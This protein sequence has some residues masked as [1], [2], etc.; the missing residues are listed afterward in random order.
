MI[1]C[2]NSAYNSYQ[3]LYNLPPAINKDVQ[4]IEY[5]PKPIHKISRSRKSRIN[6]MTHSEMNYPPVGQLQCGQNQNVATP[7][8]T[9]MTTAPEIN[10]FN[11]GSH[12]ESKFDQNT[13]KKEQEANLT[14]DQSSKMTLSSPPKNKWRVIAILIWV[15]TWGVTDG[16]PGALLPRIE[17]YYNINYIKVSLIWMFNAIG[18]IVFAVSAHKL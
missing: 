9:I 10:E 18:F 6:T 8:P 3:I 14:E 16:A 7:M 11:K 17:T 13:D 12:L 2:L 5:T 4:T 15:T 1:E